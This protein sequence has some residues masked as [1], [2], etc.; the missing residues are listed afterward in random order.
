[1]IRSRD[2]LIASDARVPQPRQ[3]RA[4]LAEVA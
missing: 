2:G 1:V 4:L 3:A